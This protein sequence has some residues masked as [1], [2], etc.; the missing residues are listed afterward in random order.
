[1]TGGG[2]WTVILGGM[3][4]TYFLRLSFIAFF[5]VDRLPS[6]LRRSLQYVPAAVLS[7][8]VLPAVLMP[9]GAIS[10][11]MSNDRLLAAMVALLAGWRARNLWATIAAG[12]LALLVLSF[13]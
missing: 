7:A 5:P 13:F 9:D 2:I 1:M 3:I 12:M 6:G 11:S 8:L 10:L 4:V